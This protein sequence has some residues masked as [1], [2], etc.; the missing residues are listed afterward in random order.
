MRV[1][2]FLRFTYLLLLGVLEAASYLFH[3]V[4]DDGCFSFGLAGLG[5]GVGVLGGGS[6][7]LHSGGQDERSLQGAAMAVAVFFLTG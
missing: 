4:D 2:L 1:E 3:D 7:L 5:F 6:G